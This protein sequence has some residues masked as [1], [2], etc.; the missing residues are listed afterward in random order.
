MRLMPS[1]PRLNRSLRQGAI[2]SASLACA[3]VAVVTG[4]AHPSTPAKPSPAPGIDDM[5]VSV[6]DVRRIAKADDLSPH[7]EA[8]LHKPAPA[9]ANAPA[10]CQPVGH[11]DLTFGGGW[12]EFRSAGYHG[13]TDD[14]QPGG[15]S[16]VN[17]VNQAVARY[18]TQEAALKAFSHL[19]TALRTCND[20]HDPNYQFTLDKP[21]SSTLRITA[22][23]WSHLY[24][25]K[26]A[27]L[28]SVGAVG[29]ESAGQIAGTV[30]G[31]I[32]DRIG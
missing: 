14:I 20:L 23:Q 16:M 32:T 1:R 30:L 28:V 21:D 7:A 12:S 25:T 8:D 3:A 26:S 10:P 17:G 2:R 18:P 9:D 13:V 31:M 29:L 5:I 22:D 24:R 27:M 4:C 6:Q 19:E 11:N 15:N